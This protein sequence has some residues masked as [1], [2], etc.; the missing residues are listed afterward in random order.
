MSVNTHHKLHYI[1][2]IVSLS[3]LAES[4]EVSVNDELIYSK[5][6]TGTFPDPQQVSVLVA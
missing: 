2:L 5:L 3:T 1:K 4:F 6:Q